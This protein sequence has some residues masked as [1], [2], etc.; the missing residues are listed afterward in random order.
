M[1]DRN[2]RKSLKSG[3]GERF[4]YHVYNDSPGFFIGSIKE[5][6]TE[7]STVLDRNKNDLGD[8]TTLDGIKKPLGMPAIYY[9]EGYGGKKQVL[10]FSPWTVGLN[11]AE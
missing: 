4:D 3:R 8:L 7:G 10:G 2:L 5:N 1:A 11:V 9:D 6:K